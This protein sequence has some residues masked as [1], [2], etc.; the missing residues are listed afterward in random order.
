MK[1]PMFVELEGKKAVVAGAGAVGSR[2]IRVLE[3]FGAEVVVVSPE[4]SD[5]VK[6]LWQSGR[7]KWEKRAVEQRDLSGAFLVVAATDSREVNHQVG[8]WCA[9]EGIFVNVADK[10]EECSFYFPGIARAGALTA[11]V[12]AG[13]TDHRLAAGAAE[14][15]RKLFRETYGEGAS[16]KKKGNGC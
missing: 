6:T 11:G 9:R 1:F 3:E 4:I 14:E 10:K 5:S 15:I 16:D 7:V 12:T 2:R 13:G 8:E